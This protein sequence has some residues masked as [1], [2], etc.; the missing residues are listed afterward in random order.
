ML[1]K[2]L[3]FYLP[4]SDYS[5]DMA[6]LI[7]KHG[8]KVTDQ[9]EC[10]TYQLKLENAKTNLTEY[11]KG[12]IYSSKWITDSISEGKILKKEDYFMCININE[13]SKRLNISKK[14][15]YTI[16]EGI[17]MFDTVGGQKNDTLK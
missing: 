9:H 10:F 3:V 13:K 1:N 17:K 16:I 4:D 7:E 8:G 6:R 5:A 11:Y 14:K 2:S 12:A 15:K